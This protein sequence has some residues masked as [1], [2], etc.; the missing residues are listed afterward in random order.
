MAGKGSAIYNTTTII[1]Y[2]VGQPIYITVIRKYF[3]AGIVLNVENSVVSVALNSFLKKPGPV[4]WQSG[5]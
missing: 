5:T 1:L 2:N 4:E 3:V